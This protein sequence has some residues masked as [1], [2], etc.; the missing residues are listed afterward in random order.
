MQTHG[1]ERLHLERDLRRA[2]D[3]EEFLIHYQPIISLQSGKVTGCEA[4]LR[5]QH[6][7]KGLVRPGEFI[8]VAEETNLIIP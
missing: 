7:D 5:W 4:L 2:L 1:V 6:P 8:P 3:R